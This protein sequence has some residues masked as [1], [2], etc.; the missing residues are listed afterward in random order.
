M[1]TLVQDKGKAVIG[2]EEILRIGEVRSW[3]VVLRRKEVWKTARYTK[4][5]IDALIVGISDPDGLTGYGYVP[6]MFLEGESAPSAEAL[7]HVVLKPVIMGRTFAGIQPLM[8]EL[9]LALR[10]NHQLK[11]AVEEALL[12]L[13]AKKLN[14]PL[15]NLLGGLCFAEMPVMRMLALKSPE[16]TAKDAVALKDKGYTYIKLKVGLDPKRD[17]AALKAVRE[18]VGVDVF[19]S[20]DANRSYTSMQAI[21]VITQMEQYGLEL[22]EQLVRA[23]DIRGMAFVRSHVQTPIMADE[24]VRTPAEAARLIEAGAIDAVSIK[25]WNVGGFMKGKEIAAVC[26]ANNCLCHI[27]STPGSRLM[28]AGQLHFAASTPNMFGGCELG[29]FDPLL[30]DP[31]SGLEIENGSLKVPMGAGL[32]V[33]VDLSQAIETTPK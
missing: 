7:L 16:D 9:E 14:T 10:H 1:K 13:Q 23:D 3:R 12:D 15:F 25:L 11:F 17:V 8:N 2:A 20:I 22:A 31:A 29:E 18:A 6:A 30:D 32:G 5:D 21:R 33:D 28:E 4:G 26:N 24:G 27:A 19:L